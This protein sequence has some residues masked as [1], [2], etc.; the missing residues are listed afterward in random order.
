MFE[1]NIDNS[2]Q[3]D[4]EC[5]NRLLNDSFAKANS[6]PDG[7]N[8]FI[9]SLSASGNNEFLKLIPEIKRYL[10]LLT[11]QNLFEMI[12]SSISDLWHELCAILPNSVRVKFI[13]RRKSVESALRKIVLN[14]SLGKDTINDIFAF[15]IIIDSTDGE[16]KNIEYCEIT[17]NF[18]T[19]YFKNK[20][21]CK[22][23]LLK[24]YITNPKKNGYKSIHLIFNFDTAFSENVELV[25]PPSFEIQI[26]TM[27]MDIDNEYGSAQHAAFKDT[28][29]KS[30]SKIKFDVE[31]I[32][33]P[34][35]RV[36]QRNGEKIIVDNIGLVKA[37]HVEERHKTF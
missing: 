23:F 20:R 10:I 22:L 35:F 2:Q 24:D 5:F 26:R 34:H 8:K 14:P 11:S 3:L 32:N 31:K 13:S 6:V 37:L 33:I 30:V 17:K 21:K 1:L 12:R 19:Q 15:R 28:Q 25:A 16:E 27:N 18:C 29:Y 36:I 4:L 9:E 7:L